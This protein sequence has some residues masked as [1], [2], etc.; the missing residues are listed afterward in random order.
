MS[1]TKRGYYFKPSTKMKTNIVGVH[2]SN[3]SFIT[4]WDEIAWNEFI[5]WFQKLAQLR[6]MGTQF[7]LLYSGYVP[8]YLHRW[9]SEVE[10][11]RYIPPSLYVFLYFSISLSLYPSISLYVFSHLPTGLLAQSHSRTQ[12]LSLSLYSLSFTI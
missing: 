1:S 5:V 2:Y 7:E 3:T 9:I 6:G 10:E 12:S 11:S 8:P 4:V